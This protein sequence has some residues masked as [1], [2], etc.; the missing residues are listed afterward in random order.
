MNWW[1]W[2]AEHFKNRTRRDAQK[3]MALARSDDPDAAAEEERE[4]NRKA[5]ALQRKREAD[6]QPQP[7]ATS[8][9]QPRWN[10]KTLPRPS[11]G[12]SSKSSPRGRAMA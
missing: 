7:G 11:C 1:K 2:Y 8:D 5:K 3:V 6:E 9:S 10:G 4:K 12:T